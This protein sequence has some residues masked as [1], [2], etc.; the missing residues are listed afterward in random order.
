MKVKQITSSAFTLLVLALP[1]LLATPAETQKFDGGGCRRHHEKMGPFSDWSEP[2]NL[3][4]SINTEFDEFHMAISQNELSLFFAGDRP[5]TLGGYD[6]WVAGRPS[7]DDDWGPARNLGPKLNTPLNEAGPLLS[8][9]EHW[10]LFCSNGHGGF[11][12][13]DIFA[14]FRKDTSDNFGWE[15]PI[16]LGEGVNSEFGDCDPTLFIDTETGVVTLYFASTRP[17]LGDWDIYQ[18]TL[19]SDGTFGPAVLVPE[20][21]SP[22]RDAH[23]TIRCDGL[24][25]FLASNR[26]GTLGMI[27]LWVSTRTTTHDA[28]STPVN[29][30]STINT[31]DNE[32]APYLSADGQ[33]LFFTSDRPGGFGG[34]DFYMTTRTR[35]CDDD[36]DGGSKPCNEK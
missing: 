33:T 29:L 18:S 28:W 3:G 15:E 17:G 19:G 13:T 11:G 25:I 14:S 34:N 16:N 2:V 23:P 6:L 32:R 12:M 8:P 21:S 27:D 4:P 26:P 20:L 10:L 31:P 9:D 30:G 24:E 5:G 36:N 1:L 22:Q 7:R 35:L